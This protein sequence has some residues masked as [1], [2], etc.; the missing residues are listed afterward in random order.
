MRLSCDTPGVVHLAQSLEDFGIL[1]RTFTRDTVSGFISGDA[2][3]F[4]V[5]IHD[6]ILQQHEE[7]D[8]D[9]SVGPKVAG[10]EVE[11]DGG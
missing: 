9:F 10:I 1:A 5:D 11:L 7:V 8:P 4:H 6:V 3:V 2:N